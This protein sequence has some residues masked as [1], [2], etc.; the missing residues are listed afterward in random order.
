V[1]DL[2]FSRLERTLPDNA[3]DDAAA[4]VAARRRDPYQAAQDLL[5]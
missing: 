2:L 3:F 4:D 1:G 5:A